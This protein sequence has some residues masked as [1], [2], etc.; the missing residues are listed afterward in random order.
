MKRMRNLMAAAIVAT[1]LA[2][3]NVSNRELMRM[4][5]ADTAAFCDLARPIYWARKDTLDTI[6]QIKAH[7]SV[8]K[9][10]GWRGK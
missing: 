6:K 9:I 1:A 7:N 4:A 8:G 3:C 5:T 10:C 2:G